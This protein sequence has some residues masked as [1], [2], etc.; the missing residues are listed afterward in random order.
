MI[1]NLSAW[2]VEFKLIGSSYWRAADC[3]AESS[4]SESPY[5]LGALR[6]DISCDSKLEKSTDVIEP[7]AAV[8]QPAT[9]S[10]VSVIERSCE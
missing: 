1:E 8:L 4:E 9:D 3:I 7:K 5:F 10:V 2:N 6:Y